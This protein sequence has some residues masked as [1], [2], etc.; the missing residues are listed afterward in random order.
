MTMTEQADT[1]RTAS[2][3]S[4]TM[5]AAQMTLVRDG[6]QV[7]AITRAAAAGRDR[8]VATDVIDPRSS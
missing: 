5:R 8:A 7:A 1:S 3:A 2:D 4:R 6:R